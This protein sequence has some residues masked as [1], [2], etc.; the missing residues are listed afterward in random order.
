MVYDKCHPDC[1]RRDKIDF[2]WGGIS[3]EI[4]ESG[5]RLSSFETISIPEFK[6]SRK[7]GALSVFFS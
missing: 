4:K 7:N 3:H 1:A 5:S 6:L 2:A